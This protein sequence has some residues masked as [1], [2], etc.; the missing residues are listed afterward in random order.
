[1]KRNPKSEPSAVRRWW[2]VIGTDLVHERETQGE[3][4]QICA[5]E[6]VVVGVL[7]READFEYLIHRSV[8][9]GRRTGR[10]CAGV[11]NDEMS[12]GVHRCVAVCGDE[13]S[14]RRRSQIDGAKEDDAELEPGIT[15]LLRR[16]GRCKRSEKAMQNS[17]TNATRCGFGQGRKRALRLLEDGRRTVMGAMSA[18]KTERFRVSWDR[19]S[20]GVEGSPQRMRTDATDGKKARLLDAVS[21]RLFD[22]GSNLNG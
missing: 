9:K 3:R 19:V 10:R 2:L 17:T 22:A 12:S 6:D 21:T 16:R 20:E 14:R 11:A 18:E 8:G 15:G 1:M 5:G 7:G 13:M 4:R